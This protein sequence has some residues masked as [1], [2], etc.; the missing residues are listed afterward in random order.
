[1]CLPNGNLTHSSY[2]PITP[3]YLLTNE[4]HFWVPER[5][6]FFLHARKKYA[7][8]RLEARF[9]RSHRVITRTDANCR[10]RPAYRLKGNAHSAHVR[11]L[12]VPGICSS[13]DLQL[14]GSSC[15]RLL[16][17]GALHLI[18]GEIGPARN[19]V[20]QSSSERRKRGPAVRLSRDGGVKNLPL[21]IYF[22][23]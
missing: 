11:P 8:C 12:S 4:C 2:W 14:M 3:L 17:R 5:K 19:Q 7:S 15:A 6:C 16:R 10:T 22:A 9:A 20:C 1:M 21:V 18:L 23:C 13:W